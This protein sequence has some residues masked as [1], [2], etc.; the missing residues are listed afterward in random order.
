MTSYYK[1]NST[2]LVLGCGSS[3]LTD[4]L[5]QRGH[6]AISTDYSSVVCCKQ[7]QIYGYEYAVADCGAPIFRQAFDMVIEKGVIDA[8]VGKGETNT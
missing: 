8:L 5:T 6:Y 1:P 3:R 4:E 7:K 2:V